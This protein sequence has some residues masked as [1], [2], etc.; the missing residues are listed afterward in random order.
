MQEHDY[1]YAEYCDQESYRYREYSVIRWWG[2][3]TGQI[4][5]TPRALRGTALNFRG[6]REARC[7]SKAENESRIKIKNVEGSCEYA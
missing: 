3:G 1:R 5:L 6:N 2:Q 4:A 7:L